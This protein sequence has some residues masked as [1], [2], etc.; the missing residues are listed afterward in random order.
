PPTLP[1]L[2]PYTTLFRSRETKASREPRHFGSPLISYA[3]EKNTPFRSWA[4]SE[5]SLTEVSSGSETN[6]AASVLPVHASCATFCTKSPAKLFS[7]SRILVRPNGWLQ[8]IFQD[9]SASTS[10]PSINA[11]T[12]S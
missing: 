1:T 8:R 5:N 12:T 10:G 3:Y 7:T 6:V 9:T 2:F 11:L 4:S